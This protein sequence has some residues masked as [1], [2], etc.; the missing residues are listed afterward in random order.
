MPNQTPQEIINDARRA[1]IGLSRSAASDEARRWA[2]YAGVHINT[3]YGWT[4]DIRPKRPTR[5]D[6]GKRAADMNHPMV[7]FATE[8]VM[9]RGRLDPDLA[10]AQT[11]L[12]FVNCADCAKLLG[13]DEYKCRACETDRAHGTP[14]KFP[15]SR[16]T[17]LRYLREHGLDRKQR[18]ASRVLRPHRRFEA[19]APMDI[20]QFD[21]T[22]L[23]KRWYWDIT[24]RR[25]LKLGELEVSDNHANENP[26]RLPIWC[27]QIIDDHSRFRFAQFYPCQKPNATHVIDFLWAAF[28]EMGIPRVLY[29]DN[30]PIIVCQ[31]TRDAVAVLDRYYSSL[32]LGGC[33]MEQHVAGNPNATGKI[34]VAHQTLAKFFNLI[35]ARHQPPSPDE[36]DGLLVE[37]CR[38]KN[39]VE[40]HSSTGMIPAIR[41]RAGYEPKRM[42]P[43][44]ILDSAFKA[45]RLSLY[46][47]TA[48]TISVGNVEYQLPRTELVRGPGAAQDSGLRTQDSDS[49]DSR[50]QTPDS[51]LVPNPFLN[52]A[53]K[54]GRNHKIDVIWP[55]DA[56][57]FLAIADEVI[58]EI[59]R[60]VAVADEAGQYKVTAETVGQK[61]IKA[62]TDSAK[63]RK[64][65]FRAQVR[66][67]DQDVKDGFIDKAERDR[68]VADFDLKVPLLNSAEVR[69]QRSK[70]SPDMES[71]PGALATRSLSEPPTVAGGQVTLL[72]RK[73]IET[74]PS[75]LAALQSDRL[76]PSLIDGRMIDYWA[77]LGRLIEEGAITASEFDKA[78]LKSQF[79]GREEIKERELRDALSQRVS[80]PTVREGVA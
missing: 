2:A 25:I 39:W 28:R 6:K 58:Y 71:V 43:P 14:A 15:V 9:V 45:D 44:A 21:I 29:T 13:P 50:L 48:V 4:K 60:V 22:G 49:P 65:A 62:I 30:D 54:R 10:I 79:A 56:D 34:E 80:S 41:F 5:S 59:P 35:A 36:L 72:P 17:F 63:E 23:K 69:G 66:Q 38:V 19:K 26:N 51:G 55:P 20:Y 64:R 46:I 8:A 57:Y 77:A 32:G 61:T 52:R 47:T 76:P 18:R 70:V 78:W 24:T 12:N 16:G 3:V 31:K 73:R 68:I 27:F 74:D 67:I 37:A 11:E 7:R 1:M 40:P 42:P 33:R 53:G 75:L